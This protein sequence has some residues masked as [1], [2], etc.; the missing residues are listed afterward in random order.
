M[1]STGHRVAEAP[2]ASVSADRFL[3][4]VPACAK[5]FYNLVYVPYAA[6]Y[7]Q[8]ANKIAETAAGYR[9]MDRVAGILV[10]EFNGKLSTNNR[11]DSTRTVYFPASLPSVT[12]QYGG[13]LRVE[14]PSFTL[15]TFKAY[16][17]A[18]LAQKE[19]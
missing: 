6:V 17:R 7:P 10:S 4:E 9:E 11:Q 18:V 19:S 16:A 5:R 2:T 8:V 1:G 14:H 3:S 13:H 15:R 12:V